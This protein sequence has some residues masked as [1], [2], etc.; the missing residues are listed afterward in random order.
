MG[1]DADAEAS[2]Q[3]VGQQAQLFKVWA[4]EKGRAMQARLL[5]RPQQV[6]SMKKSASRA[7][8]PRNAATIR[9]RMYP[10]TDNACKC[11]T[12][13]AFVATQCCFRY[14]QALQTDLAFG[15][16]SE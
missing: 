8:A 3:A 6:S 10:A 15:L 2:L 9:P 7:E 4:Y 16:A 11:M 13:H 5:E 14:R 12:H 1:A